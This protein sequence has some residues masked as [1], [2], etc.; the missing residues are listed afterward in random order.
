MGS[1]SGKDATLLESYSNKVS[2]SQ[3]KPWEPNGPW[4]GSAGG[5]AGW[6]RL[7]Q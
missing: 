2:F 6:F 5:K 4:A 3:K 7:I 1:Y